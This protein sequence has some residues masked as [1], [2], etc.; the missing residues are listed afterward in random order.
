M[1]QLYFLFFFLFQCHITSNSDIR[2]DL[3]GLL[4][5]D[6]LNVVL[7]SKHR[8]RCIIEF[9]SQ[10]LQMLDFEEHRRSVMVTILSDRSTK[11]FQIHDIICILMLVLFLV[12]GV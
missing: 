9:I 2:K 6:D 11:P 3:Q 12:V 1:L 8:P 10:S 5:E 4:S 7:S